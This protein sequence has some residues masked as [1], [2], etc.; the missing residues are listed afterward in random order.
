MS[1]V[2]YIPKRH[3]RCPYQPLSVRWSISY[4]KDRPFHYLW[5]LYV[6]TDPSYGR[7]LTHGTA[8]TN[9]RAYR[10]IQAALTEYSHALLAVSN[11]GPGYPGERAHL[12]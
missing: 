2:D 7:V 9:A 6:G 12:P 1:R 3:R 4:A 10:A 5:K 8:P 11:G